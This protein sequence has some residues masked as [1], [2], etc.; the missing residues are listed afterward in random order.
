MKNL[1]TYTGP[2]K[3]FGKEDKVL[4]KIQIDNSLDLGWKREDILLA[5]DFPFEYNG[6]KSLV[7]KD[8]IYYDFDLAAS[9][10]PVVI[11]LINQGVLDP[12]QLYW[13]HD[14]DAYELNKID[15]AELSLENVD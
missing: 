10:L 15:E 5:T 8:E 13:C 14:F 6:V 3:K 9:K 1:L 4:A 2:K 7:I 12:G 11:Y